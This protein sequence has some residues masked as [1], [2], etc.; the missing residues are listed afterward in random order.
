[1]L[2]PLLEEL[3]VE[4]G[5]ASE[6]LLV[7]VQVVEGASVDVGSADEVHSVVE[8]SVE[9]ASAD[10]VE[11]QVVDEATSV[12]V[13]L[14]LSRVL[15]R[16]VRARFALGLA[17]RLESPSCAARRFRWEC[18]TAP[19]LL[20]PLTDGAREETK[21]ATP[22]TVNKLS[23]LSEIIVVGAKGEGSFFA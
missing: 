12:L 9:V 8:A 11:D 13:P 22:P 15:Q 2:D 18:L 16:F 7:G 17:T 1:M 4:L 21:R 14:P 20:R 3:P 23:N 6:E 5:A 19:T 10:Q